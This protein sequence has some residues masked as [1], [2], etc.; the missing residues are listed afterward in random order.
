MID[1]VRFYFQ[2]PTSKA[3]DQSWNANQSQNPHIWHCQIL[4]DPKRFR[5]LDGPMVITSGGTQNF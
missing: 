5:N 3:T 1:F 4:I 2:Y